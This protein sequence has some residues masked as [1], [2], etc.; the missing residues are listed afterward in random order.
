MRLWVYVAASAAV[1]VALMADALIMYPNYYSAMVGMSDSA[2]KL[3]ALVNFSGTMTILCTKLAA[4]LL[5]DGLNQADRQTISGRSLLISSVVV[6]FWTPLHRQLALNS[7]AFL[8][9]FLFLLSLTALHWICFNRV[10]SL[11][12]MDPLALNRRK[13]YKIAKLGCICALFFA[14]DIALCF[15][16]FTYYHAHE[17]TGSFLSCVLVELV[18]K[19]VLFSGMY[20]TNLFNMVYL[21]RNPDEDEWDRAQLVSSL[22]KLASSLLGVF[23]HVYLIR[24]Y[25]V[26]IVRIWL[27]LPYVFY[28]YAD[29][30]AVHKALTAE[31][32]LSKF[33]NEASQQDLERDNTCVICREEMELTASAKHTPKRLNC[34]HVMHM[35]CLQSWLARS[36]SCPTCR[37]SVYSK[38]SAFNLQPD[39]TSDDANAGLPALQRVFP[40]P[41]QDAEPQAQVQQPQPQPQ[42]PQPQPHEQTEPAFV[43][44]EPEPAQVPPSEP[45][46]QSDVD[47]LVKLFPEL[48]M[49]TETPVS[50]PAVADH[51]RSTLWS[52]F[53]PGMA[54]L[55]TGEPMSCVECVCMD[56]LLA[57]VCEH[58]PST[59]SIRQLG[60]AKLNAVKRVAATSSPAEP[61]TVLHQ[62]YTAYVF[63]ELLRGST[64]EPEPK[65][66]KR[67]NLV[68]Q[69]LGGHS[70][71]YH[72]TIAE[73]ATKHL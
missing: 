60:A 53:E 45:L 72:Y 17:L 66:R 37:Q 61:S 11:Q 5:F 14:T 2:F 56:V 36:R 30:N 57:F 41:R 12:V 35:A 46:R 29:V 54:T 59:V 49:Y 39:E 71:E 20:A 4:W 51:N 13:V 21:Y 23:S 19:S 32:E 3:L 43:I 34:G 73:R 67:D 68:Y 1:Y 48:E 25:S 50:K 40:Q 58:L 52:V 64:P 6:Q 9:G 26:S 44:A 31:S 69:L 62:R 63:V 47:A 24:M 15:S 7:Q 18:T 16:T 38:T 65:P 22:V 8:V 55:Q 28:A 33:T 70:R 27:L 10:K 42:Q